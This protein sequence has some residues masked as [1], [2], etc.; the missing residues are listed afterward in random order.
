MAGAVLLT[1]TDTHTLV[2]VKTVSSSDVRQSSQLMTTSKVQKN[3]ELIG[4]VVT[5]EIII[6]PETKFR[7]IF[8][9]GFSNIELRRQKMPMT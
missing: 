7:K 3:D 5:S 8:P 4:V 9:K 2:T 1:P 6:I